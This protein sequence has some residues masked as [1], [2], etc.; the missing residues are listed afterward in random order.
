MYLWELMLAF[1]DFLRILLDVP[2]RSQWLPP[3]LHSLIWASSIPRMEFVQVL[4]VLVFSP[5]SFRSSMIVFLFVPFPI[6][7]RMSCNAVSN[8]SLYDSLT[9]RGGI[10]LTA[11]GRSTSRPLSRPSFFLSGRLACMLVYS[12]QSPRH[13]ALK[14]R[15]VHP[16]FSFLQ[17]FISFFAFW[18]FYS[19][20]CSAVWF[21]AMRA[22]P[23]AAPADNVQF[24]IA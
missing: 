9:E 24:V 10:S 17:R 3:S 14:R 19:V 2:Y 4:P 16:L 11:A 8:W 18:T 23:K 13:C 22:H 12:G 21:A 6:S 5:R 7:Q 20:T 1:S 15:Q